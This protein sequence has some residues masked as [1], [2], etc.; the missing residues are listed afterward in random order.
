VDRAALSLT[1]RERAL[2][3]RAAAWPGCALEELTADR[4]QEITRSEGVDFATALLFDRVRRSERYGPFIARL[5]AEAD[6]GPGAWP[7]GVTLAVVPGAFHVDR[8][9]TGADGK[10]LVALA[11]R[12]GAAAVTVPLPGFGSVRAGARVL[13]DWLR[14][15]PEE[16]LLLASLS[17]GGAEVKVA[18][19]DPAA[20]EA[21]RK[22]RAWVNLSGLLYGTPLVDW[23]FARPLRT[24][25][26][27]LFCWLH[28]Y[29][30]QGVRELRRGPEALLSAP[31]RL[32]PHVTAVHLFG[33]PLTEHLT[34][35]LSRRG[36]RRVAVLGP[37]DGGAN[38]LTD[39][40]DL[41]G[42]LYPVWGADHYLRPRR[43]LDGVIGPLLRFLAEDALTA[44]PA[45]AG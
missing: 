27:R 41:P 28:G 33:F 14:G 3:D 2:L 31:L 17:K 32:P 19:A 22:V 15:R 8:P 35:P 20:G 40:L 21:F 16:T 30:F 23:L 38:L 7:S 25:F 11:R 42:F 26:I 39:M 13:V 43:D 36:H 5:E 24:I 45:S 18:L 6:G 10:F 9:E 44:R 12:Y 34:T 37:N 1:A 4:V 29:D